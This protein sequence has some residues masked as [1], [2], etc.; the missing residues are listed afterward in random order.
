MMDANSQNITKEFQKH[1]LKWRVINFIKI[2]LLMIITY[3]LWKES[4][5]DKND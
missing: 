4:N 2:S 1:C 3:N 5:E